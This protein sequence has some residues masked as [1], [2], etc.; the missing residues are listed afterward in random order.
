MVEIADRESAEAWLLKQSHQTQ[1]W[2][3]SRC[4]LRALPGLADWDEATKTGLTYS[5]LRALLIATAVATCSN[6]DVVALADAAALSHRSVKT[7]ADRAINSQF[8]Q[9]RSAALATANS[10]A[11]AAASADS[12][13]RS[14]QSA[15]LSASRACASSALSG[16]RLSV[17]GQFSRLTGLKPAELAAQSE[18]AGFI[19]ASRD[20]A[21]STRWITLWQPEEQKTA[22]D[23]SWDSLK[24]I[25]QADQLD[26]TFWI[27]WYEA[28]LAGRPLPWELTQRIAL[29]VERKDWETGQGAVAKRIDEI[30]K[31]FEGAPLDKEGLRHMQNSLPK[32]LS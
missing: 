10:V 24:K 13:A 4:A 16:A 26:W 25:L 27:E 2:F 9:P 12:I 6:N 8:L 32:T 7:A 20:A 22:L 5:V 17:I 29:E 18:K 23:G 15:A 3:A 19:A 14:H 28:I 31:D 21:N 1:V 30:R 11:F